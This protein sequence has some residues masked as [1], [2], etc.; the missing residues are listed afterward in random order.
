MWKTVNEAL[1]ILFAHHCIDYKKNGTPACCEDMDMHRNCIFLVA[2]SANCLARVT[3][4][5][6][7]HSHVAPDTC[8]GN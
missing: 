1:T 7:R 4:L 5:L 8:T 6:T 3:S 2:V